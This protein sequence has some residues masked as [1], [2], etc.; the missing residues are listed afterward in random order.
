MTIQSWASISKAWKGKEKKVVNF[1]N[2]ASK[3][4]VL[5]EL[6]F[7]QFWLNLGQKMS[8]YENLENAVKSIVVIDNEIGSRKLS[9][10]QIINTW[11]FT[12]SECQLVWRVAAQLQRYDNGWN[13]CSSTQGAVQSTINSNNP[14]CFLRCLDFVELRCRILIWQ[15]FCPWIN[16]IELSAKPYIQDVDVNIY[17][18]KKTLVQV[19]Q[20]NWN[21]IL[22]RIQT[23][24]I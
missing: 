21:S 19:G 20:R 10:V 6:R 22:W 4:P 13:R 7:I 23:E 18:T 24:Y 9:K 16:T 14:V 12:Q 11:Y 2:L 1:S 15:W 17:A 5:A 3:N 8:F